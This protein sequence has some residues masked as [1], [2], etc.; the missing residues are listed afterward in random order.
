M[1]RA[2]SNGSKMP[3]MDPGPSSS[4][5]KMNI[6]LDKSQENNEL[7]E[8]LDLDYD[9][10]DK[11][12]TQFYEKEAEKSTSEAPSKRNENCEKKNTGKN[13]GKGIKKSK[14]STNEPDTN[15]AFDDDDDL[16]VDYQEVDKAEKQYYD[17]EKFLKA[18]QEL[19][20]AR[21]KFAEKRMR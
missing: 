20:M 17:F 2:I 9:E 21:M 1:A 12:C 10:V 16:D 15:Q 5:S 19:A 18:E 8:D 3:K 4:T 13:G 11:A 14:K 6:T 7:S